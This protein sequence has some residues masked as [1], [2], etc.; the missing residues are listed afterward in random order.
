METKSLDE[1]LGDEPAEVIDA[2]VV[3]QPVETETEAEARARDEKG[4]F[5]PKGD[6]LAAPPA[7]EDHTS[8]GLEAATADER[9]K[10]QASHD[11]LA[12]IPAE[13]EPPT[14]PPPA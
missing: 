2:P 3:E 11:Q 13:L 8:K 12:A 14:T 7:S 1:L 6:E 4:R 10:R 5:A 9:R